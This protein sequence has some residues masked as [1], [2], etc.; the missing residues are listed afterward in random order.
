EVNLAQANE[1][2]VEIG[3]QSP[4]LFQRGLTTDQTA[5]GTG[6]GFPFNNTQLLGVQQLGNNPA[7]RPGIVGYQGVTG[8]GVGRTSPRVNA[9]GLVVSASSNSVNLL[10]RALQTQNRLD[11]LS[12][13]QI[14][15]MDNQTAI[16]SVAQEIPYLGTTVLTA[17]GA[18]QQ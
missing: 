18:S 10:I 7:V 5:L 12:R 3:L 14:N 15:V 16:I 2:G 17:T 4:V 1:F 13:P 8:L 6:P 9:S 11:I